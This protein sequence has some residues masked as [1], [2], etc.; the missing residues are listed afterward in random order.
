VTASFYAVDF[1][2]ANF[3]FAV[4]ADGVICRYNGT[5]WVAVNSGVTTAFRSVLIVDDNTIVV[6][7]DGGLVCLSTD[8]GLTWQTLSVG[9]SASLTTLALA[10]DEVL[11]F[12]D[13]GTGFAFF[14]SPPPLT[15]F[16]ITAFSYNPT[17]RTVNLTFLSEPGINYTIE[18]S[19]NGQTWT[20]LGAPV[21]GAAGA[22]S[23]T[24]TGRPL[25][26]P[27]TDR[28]LLRVRH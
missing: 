9:T 8:G 4:G 21:P 6:S 11:A 19:F 18:T 14:V 20:V 25:Q 26:P 28:L 15:P 10:G 17:A 16:S 5:S 23:T 3:G 24:V 2:R 13:G 7:G 27:Y 1:L 22:T 12:G